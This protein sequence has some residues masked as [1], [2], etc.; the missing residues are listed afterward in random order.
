M[1][2]FLSVG[3]IINT[4]GIRGELKVSPSTSDV[5]RFEYLYHVF[6]DLSPTAVGRG[7]AKVPNA[8]DLKK[9]DVENTRFHQTAV[10]LTLHG[11]DTMSDAEKLKGRELWVSREDAR[12][13]DEDEWFICDLIGL[14]V[15]EE[16]KLLGTLTAVI[17]TGSNDVYVVGKNE[18]LIPAIQDVILT[19][20]IAG[21]RVDVKLPAGLLDIES[22]RDD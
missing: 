22:V 16:D 10:L 12:E 13:L 4:H 21:G 2:D 9:Y 5:S 20:D 1:E 8:S 6:I 17:Q 3:R 14:K 15:Y 18:I 7:D 19:V 11:V